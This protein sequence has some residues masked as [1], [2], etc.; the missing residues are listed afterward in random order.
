MRH[1]PIALL[2]VAVALV[3]WTF[4]VR[5]EAVQQKQGDKAPVALA[6]RV[7]ELQTRLDRIAP[8]IE[9]LREQ[10]AALSKY[11]ILDEHIG[12]LQVAFETVDHRFQDLEKKAHQHWW[13][14]PPKR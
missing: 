2:T 4:N 9:R 11:V 8:E 6:Q 1:L 7:A 3:L 13:K 14:E 12:R 10:Q 5:I